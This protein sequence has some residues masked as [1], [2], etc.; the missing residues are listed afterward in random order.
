MTMPLLTPG[1]LAPPFALT[2]LGSGRS[3]Q[4]AG[5][6]DALLLVFHDQ[7]TVDAV[8]AMQESLRS[9]YVDPDRLQIASVVNMKAVPV[10]LRGAAETVMKSSYAKAAA[11][12]PPG[13]DAADY[14]VIL[15]DWDGSV[16]KA[17]GALKITRQ[18]RL[19]LLDRQGTVNAVHQEAEFGAAALAM[20]E[21]LLGPLTPGL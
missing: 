17:Y 8:Q 1:E 19:V 14:V 9:R 5:S 13:L 11:V 21:R 18:P 16:S 10:F 4:P 2:A 20:V 6:S 15:L 7:N 12:M 3:V